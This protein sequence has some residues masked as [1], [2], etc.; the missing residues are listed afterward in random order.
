MPALTEQ[1]C[2]QRIALN[3]QASVQLNPNH[4]QASTS[5]SAHT[6]PAQ[7]LDITTCGAGLLCTQTLPQGEAVSVE[8]SLPDYEQDHIMRVEGQVTHLTKTQNRYLIG[9]QFTQ[10]TPH[11]RLV[12][13]GFIAYHQRFEA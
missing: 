8:F 6:L 12:I 13:Q 7:L 11:Q 5:T 10:L 2:A 1:R 3:R 9:M 4:P